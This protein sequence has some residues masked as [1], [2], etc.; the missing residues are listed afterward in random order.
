M[1]SQSEWNIMPNE[2]Q[3]KWNIRTENLLTLSH[4]GKENTATDQWT[5]MTI[6]M[7]T[8]TVL[9]HQISIFKIYILCV[10]MQKN[11]LI[12][13]LKKKKK[14]NYKALFSNQS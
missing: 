1:C 10:F 7:Y 4:S 9:S 11:C 13:I 3:K 5:N 14:K 6:C 2:K 12:I 8:Y